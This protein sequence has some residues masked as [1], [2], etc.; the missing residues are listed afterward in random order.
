MLSIL[1]FFFLA[2][3]L[4]E[5]ESWVENA[6]S[7]H[8]INYN[9]IFTFRK[10]F[11][12]CAVNKRG[13]IHTCFGIVLCA[14]RI[15]KPR[16]KENFLFFLFLLRHVLAFSHANSIHKIDSTMQNVEHGFKFI[17][18]IAQRICIFIRKLNE[19]S[20]K[21]PAS[22]FVL[23]S[24]QLS[25]VVSNWKPITI[26]FYLDHAKRYWTTGKRSSVQNYFFFLHFDD[27]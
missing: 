27:A 17:C 10:R 20:E 6:F 4:L 1:L 8:G 24:L 9:S 5:C 21:M 16:A 23:C 15:K 25:T 3:Q 14:I 12:A 7:S 2:K 26:S 11:F 19:T 18:A 22:L 13:N